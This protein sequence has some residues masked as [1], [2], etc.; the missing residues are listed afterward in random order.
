MTETTSRFTLRQLPLPAKLVLTVFL[1]SV[2]LGYSSAMVQLHMQHSD[3]DGEVLPPK[4][5]VVAIFSGKV[6]K[7]GNDDE[8]T[9]CRLEEILPPDSNGRVNSKNMTPALF[10]QDEGAYAEAQRKDPA[11]AAA[12]APLREGERKVLIAWA[13]AA[14]DTR[15][16]SYQDDRFELPNDLVGKPFTPNYKADPKTVRIHSLLRDRC[17]RCH[18]PGGEKGDISLTTYE[19]ISKYLPVAVDVP[20]GGGWVDSGRQMSLEKLTQSST[21]TCSA[22]PCCSPAPA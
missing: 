20:P 11:K 14:P 2:G 1:L 3:R 9:V 7:K 18:K 12:L 10:G 17:I 21:H 8:K 6:W 13:N 16:K 5:N 22:S 4:E 15:K 19:G